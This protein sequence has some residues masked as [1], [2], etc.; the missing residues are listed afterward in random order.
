M[1]LSTAPIEAE[2]VPRIQE[3][4]QERLPAGWSAKIVRQPRS[5]SGLRPDAWLDLVAP[6]GTTGRMAVEVKASLY[7]RNASLLR[8]E[9]TLPAGGQPP[10]DGILIASR[11]LTSRTREMLEQ[12]DLSY[13]DVTGNARIS[14]RRPP[15]YVELRGADTNPWMESRPLQ[16]LAGSSTAAV[17]RALVDF[18]PPYTV[19]ALAA[20][21]QLPLPTV[22]RVVGLLD[23]EAIISRQ[24]RGPITDVDWQAL[25]RRW[26]MDYDLFKTNRS[27]L[28]FDPR[29]VDAAVAALSNLQDTWAITGS[30]AAQVRMPFALPALLAVYLKGDVRRAIRDLG[31]RESPGTGNVV[32]LE[33]R[34]DLP[35]VRSWT[36]R[37]RRY[38]ALSQVVV[39]L[40]TG[41]GRSPSEADALLEWMAGNE[42]AWRS[43]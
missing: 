13:A 25:L 30:V 21:A 34:T 6:D 37:K 15:F 16:S 19:G 29:G 27:T 40:L 17:V 36:E 4:L 9:I 24:G 38:V 39:D 12:L 31:V 23:Q 7:P 32:L 35:F 1:N 2:I 42:N 18:R 43:T 20:L 28:L 41:P 33:P 22:S 26:A 8:R 11:F 5:R 14:I 10:F 3:L